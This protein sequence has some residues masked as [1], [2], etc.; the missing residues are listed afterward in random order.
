M[1]TEPIQSGPYPVPA[2]PPDGPNQMN[3]IVVW[4]AGRLNMRF[5]STAARD[6]AIPAPTAGMECTIGT[7]AAQ[8]KYLHDGTAWKQIWSD[9]GWIVPT[10]TGGWLNANIGVRRIGPVVY[11]RGEVWGGSLG[12]AFTT[13]EAPFRPASRVAV[14]LRRLLASTEVAKLYISTAG[15][16]S[17][18]ESN[19]GTASPG[20]GLSTVSYI[21]S[22][23]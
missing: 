3:A 14:G 5:A 15:E 13:L 19:G 6:A 20:M 12:A 16:M 4:A 22:G 23:A 2:D 10:L 18:Y 1:A 8:I 17:I 9:T 21:A 11:L 7:G